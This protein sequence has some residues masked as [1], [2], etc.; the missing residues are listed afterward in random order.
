MSRK[1]EVFPALDCE[2]F[3]AAK[4]YLETFVT[5]HGRSVADTVWMAGVKLMVS[6]LNPA[7]RH[8]SGNGNR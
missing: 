1:C 2:L 4:E 3:P 8:G 6:E 7:S 5:N